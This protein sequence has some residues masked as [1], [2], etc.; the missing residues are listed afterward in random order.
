MNIHHLV[1]TEES[2][3]LRLLRLIKDESSICEFMK[4]QKEFFVGFAVTP[5]TAKVRA[6]VC[7]K[8]LVKKENALHLSSTIF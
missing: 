6:T 1:R 2:Y 3:M 8:C 4:K 7:D 5:Q